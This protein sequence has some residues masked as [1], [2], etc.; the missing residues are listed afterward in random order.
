MGVRDGNIRKILLLQ[1][2]LKSFT[3]YFYYSIMLIAMNGT[4]SLITQNVCHLFVTLQPPGSEKNIVFIRGKRR[5]FCQLFEYN[6]KNSLT[7]LKYQKQ[8]H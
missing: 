6:D 3:F 4:N 5:N 2:L 1:N 8:N 7:E